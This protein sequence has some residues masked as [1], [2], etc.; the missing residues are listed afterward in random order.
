ME[1]A[2]YHFVGI[3]GTGMSALALI[4]KDLGYQVQGSDITKKTFTEAGLR[5]AQIPILEFAAANIQPTMTIIAGNAF[6]DSNTEIAQAQKLHLPIIRYP[7]MV[8]KLVQTYTSIAVAGT[9]GKTSTTGLLAHV[10]E[11]IA[12]TSYLIGDGTGKGV[13]NGRF[14]A[15]EADEYRRHFLAYTPDYM[16]ITNIDFDHPDYFTDR[17]DVFEAF[18]SAALQVKKNLFAWG[19]DPLLTT[20]ADHVQI[21]IYYYGFSDAV[22]FQAVN[23]QRTDQGSQF[24]V[25]HQGQQIG[26]FAIPMFGRHNILN[27]LAVIGVSYLEKISPQLIQQELATFSGVKR[28]YNERTVGDNILIDDYAHHPSEIQVTIDAARQQYPD[29]QIVAVFQPHTYSRLTALFDGFVR[30]LDLADQ[31]YLTPIFGSIREQ[32]GHITS[33]ALAAKLHKGGTVLRLEDMTPL[34]QYHDSVIIFMG[35]GDIQKYELAYQKLLQ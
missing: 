24:D 9:H 7:D 4:L 18:C 30:S 6:D 25:L 3:K 27:S 26:H 13:L 1:K 21:P 22:D 14:F 8:E 12:P 16:I 34:L 2:V 20:L 35:A 33:A 10:L 11:R 29:K 31:V 15:F 28:R 5:R 17:N 32:S 19:D 23:V